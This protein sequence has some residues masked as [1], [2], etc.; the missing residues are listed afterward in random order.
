MGNGATPERCRIGYDSGHELGAHLHFLIVHVPQTECSTLYCPDADD[1]CRRDDIARRW[2]PPRGDSRVYESR[3]VAYQSL[4]AVSHI[5]TRMPPRAHL[6][7]VTMRF[8]G[9]PIAR[10]LGFFAHDVDL[11]RTPQISAR[12]SPGADLAGRR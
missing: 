3:T 4:R 9:A 11:L 5:G 12:G 7:K 6:K 1:G 2:N 8:V 10:E